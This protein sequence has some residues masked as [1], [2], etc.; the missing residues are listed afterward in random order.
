[1]AKKQSTSKGDLGGRIG[2]SGAIR[3]LRDKSNYL[4]RE[5]I[6]SGL[7]G[8]NYIARA[9]RPGGYAKGGKV[10]QTTEFYG[11]PVNDGNGGSATY[12]PV[13]EDK[14]GNRVRGTGIS[15]ALQTGKVQQREGAKGLGGARNVAS[16]RH[17][18]RLGKNGIARQ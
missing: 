4:E 5:P 18:V 15:G 6:V 1:M 16:T 10:G 12:L 9:M 13:K 2:L 3:K 17:R 7:K 11:Y 14:M 8:P